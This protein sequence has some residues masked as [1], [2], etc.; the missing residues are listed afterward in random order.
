MRSFKLE[1]KPS[2]FYIS[3]ISYPKAI[4]SLSVNEGI[5]SVKM[6]LHMHSLAT[7][8]LHSWKEFLYLLV[9]GS[10]QL[11]TQPTVG[12]VYVCIYIYI[13]FQPW[14]KHS[15]GIYIYNLLLLISLVIFFTLFIYIKYSY[16]IQ[17]ICTL[18]WLTISTQLYGF[19]ELLLFNNNNNNN[20]T[21]PGKNSMLREKETSKYLRIL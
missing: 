7:G 13:Y 8:V 1:S 9:C 5:F 17:I 11:P 4:V 10:R 16:M 18:L 3:R 2:L 21:K 14:V 15:S 6:Y 20:N 12:S 19:K